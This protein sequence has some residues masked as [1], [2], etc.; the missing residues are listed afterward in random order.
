MSCVVVVVRDVCLVSNVYVS[1]G[2][3][4]VVCQVCVLNMRMCD[5]RHTSICNITTSHSKKLWTEK[6][7]IETKKNDNALRLDPP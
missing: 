3:V 2:W 4:C 1:A 6:R 5:V 7:S